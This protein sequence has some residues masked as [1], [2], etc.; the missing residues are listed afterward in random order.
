MHPWLPEHAKFI[1]AELAK[2]DVTNPEE[3]ADLRIA[4]DRKMQKYISENAVQTEPEI[5]AEEA[6]A[7]PVEV[8]TPTGENDPVEAETVVDSTVMSEEDFRS[9]SA[10]D[11]RAV[12]ENM[13]VEGDMSNTEKRTELYLS[14]LSAH[15]NAV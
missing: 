12:L 5:P 9:L 14:S 3:S 11:Q 2:M 1:E 6:V 13:G 8:G 10:G 4:Y 15:A 7:D